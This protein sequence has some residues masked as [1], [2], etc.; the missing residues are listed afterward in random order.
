MLLKQ[1]KE[2]HKCHTDQGK[3]HL[4]AS[5]CHRS[6]SALHLELATQTHCTCIG[7][8]W[9]EITWSACSLLLL[10]TSLSYTLSLLHVLPF[11]ISPSPTHPSHIF[12]TILIYSRKAQ[13]KDVDISHPCHPHLPPGVWFHTL[14]PH[15]WGLPGCFP[16]DGLRTSF[17]AKSPS[18][19]P[20][21]WQAPS[22]NALRGNHVSRIQFS[23]T[24]HSRLAA[25]C[26]ALLGSC[27]DAWR[28]TCLG[29]EEARMF[30][31]HHELHVNF[32]VLIS[33]KDKSI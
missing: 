30:S 14:Q 3:I 8:H 33:N 26:V 19:V 29:K 9:A 23:A 21:I 13:A 28:H 32:W 22:T 6:L 27:S 1:T 2:K 25:S 7:F 15:N 11:S 12:L 17:L 24:L 4:S 31:F 20:S 16:W 18:L 5:Q 10:P